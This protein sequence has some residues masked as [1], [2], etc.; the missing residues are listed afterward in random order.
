MKTEITAADIDLAGDALAKPAF[1][2]GR[3]ACYFHHRADEFVAGYAAK[4]VV[5]T[6]DFDVRIADAGQAN[7]DQCPAGAQRWYGPA[8]QRQLSISDDEGEQGILGLG[9]FRKR[10]AWGRRYA[11][12]QFKFA[13][14]ANQASIEF[15]LRSG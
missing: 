3:R 5:A 7:A 2:L 9:F 1:L 13:L 15:D 12:E 6:E 11:F 8:S 14:Q 4:V 10:A